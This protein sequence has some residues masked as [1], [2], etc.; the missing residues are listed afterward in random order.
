MNIYVLL[1]PMSPDYL[2]MDFETTLRPWF[3]DVVADRD[4][5]KWIYPS[6]KSLGAYLFSINTGMIHL[7]SIR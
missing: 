1:T 5:W 2:S 7:K 6:S 3:I 4:L